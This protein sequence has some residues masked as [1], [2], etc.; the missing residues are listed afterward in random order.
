MEDSPEQSCRRHTVPE[1]F[2]KA[3]TQYADRPA[4]REK[5]GEDWRTISWAAYAQEVISASLGLAALGLKKGECVCILSENCP[6]WIYADMAIMCAGGVSAGVYPTSAPAQIEYFLS[7][8]S[9]RY[10]FASNQAQLDKLLA[11]REKFPQLRKIIILNEDVVIPDNDPDILTFDA[12]KTLG[13]QLENE[14]K[15]NSM[16]NA[17]TPDDVAILIYTSGT[18]GAPKG[19][20]L[21]HRNI[22]FEIAVHDKFLHIAEGDDLISFLPISHIAERMLTSLRPM[23]HGA[24][25]TFSRGPEKLATEIM[26]VSPHVFFAVPRIWEKFHAAINSA[27]ENASPFQRWSYRCALSIGRRTAQHK[28]SARKPPT[29]LM[30]IQKITDTLVMRKI[31]AKIGMG[32]AHF[33]ICGAAPVSPELLLWMAA[34]G[35]DVR[36][37]YGLTENGSVAAI[38]PLDQRK[39]GSV[40]KAVLDSEIKIAPDGEILIR[41]DHVFAG[42]IN[43]DEETHKT[44]KDG[45]LYTGDLGRLDSDGFLFITGRKKDIII[46][47]GGKNISPAQ[48]EN[49]LKFHALIADCMVVGDGRK[50]LTCLIML[51]PINAQEYAAKE[52]FAFAGF[53]ELSR[54]PEISEIIGDEISRVSQLYSRAEQIKAFRILDAPLALDDGMLTPTMK[55]KRDAV[56]SGYKDLIN[57]MYAEATPDERRPP[58]QTGRRSA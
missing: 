54:H 30:V 27:I 31:R 17:V 8:C 21:T 20:M 6:R 29:F 37:T 12:L 42:Y 11:I 7:D 18:T 3:T 15:F 35:L 48:I 26:E 39:L 43:K 2:L 40:G 33:V 58:A 4:L 45:W 9:A 24:R 55:L 23:M 1:I 19:V 41:G 10:I 57:E 36:E 46:T 22:M 51:D 25:V 14:N 53:A 50:Y 32:R 49:E 47:S 28:Y 38:A 34:I 5:Q 13:A 16:V 44:L 52:N 56:A